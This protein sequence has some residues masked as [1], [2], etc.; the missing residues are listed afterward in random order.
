MVASFVGGVTASRRWRAHYFGSSY[1]TI[2]VY[3]SGC[4]VG[5]QFTLLQTNTTQTIIVLLW[6]AW[7]LLSLGREPA[8]I[9]K[10]I[11][12]TCAW[13]PCWTGLGGWSDGNF[14]KKSGTCKLVGYQGRVVERSWRQKGGRL[15]GVWNMSTLVAVWSLQ[16]YGQTKLNRAERNQA[17]S[18]LLC[19]NVTAPPLYNTVSIT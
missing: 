9:P 3:K 12:A 18:L 15:R 8:L 14:M 13:L 19:C 16:G 4:N 2:L 7:S 5:R 17:H 6:H 10:H 11:V 1:H